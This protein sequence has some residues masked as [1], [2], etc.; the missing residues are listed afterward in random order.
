MI[1]QAEMIEVD[2]EDNKRGLVFCRLSVVVVGGGLRMT[3]GNS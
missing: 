2:D 1:H 3:L